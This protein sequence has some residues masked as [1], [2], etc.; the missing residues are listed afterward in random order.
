MTKSLKLNSFYQNYAWGTLS[1]IADVLKIEKPQTELPL[2]ELW[3]GAHPGLPSQIAETGQPLN[4]A[5]SAQ[6]DVFLGEQA[7]RLKNRLPYLFKILSAGKALSVQVHPSLEQAQAGFAKERANG[8]DEK[9]PKCNYKDDNHKPELIYALTNFVAMAGFRSATDI[10]QNMQLIGGDLLAPWIGQLEAGGEAAIKDFY[11]WLLY[12]PEQTL[13]QLLQSVLAAADSSAQI[14]FEWIKKLHQQYG[15]DAG[16]LFPLVL[17]LI[18][19]QPGQAMFLGAGAPHAYLRGTGIEVMANSDN[20]LRG[21]LTPKHMDREELIRVTRYD[22]QANAMDIQSGSRV[23]K[24]LKFNVPCDDFQFELLELDSTNPD[25][26]NTRHGIELYFVVDGQFE[27]EGEV[28]SNGQAWILPAQANTPSIHGSG[29]I[30]RV[31]SSL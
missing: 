28:Y 29:C 21:G 11:S 1:E 13:H 9:H 4:Q 5:I 18:Q 19:L 8:I 3:V 26:I 12:L 16:V 25:I 14:E 31:Y 27:V 6:P 17:N 20:V 22:R 24:R 23:G 2:A 10:A 15:D 7:E 30:A